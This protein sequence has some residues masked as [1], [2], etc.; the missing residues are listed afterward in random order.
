MMLRYNIVRR[1][2]EEAIVPFLYGEK[3]RDPGI[4]VFNVA[5]EGPFSFA[6]PPKGYPSNQPVPSIPDC[7][8][9][10]LSHPWVDLVLTGP[11]SRKEIDLALAAIE[12]GP[13]DMSEY[14][15]LRHYGDLYRQHIAGQ[16]RQP[17]QTAAAP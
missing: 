10:A 7:Y 9:F 2:I 5:H 11:T 1:D 6:I 13:L 12:Q 14:Q 4:V 17:E 15:A 16:S 3:E 8:R